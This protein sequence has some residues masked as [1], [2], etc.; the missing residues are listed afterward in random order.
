[1]SSLKSFLFGN[2]TLYY[3]VS[4]IKSGSY[5]WSEVNII[6]SKLSISYWVGYQIVT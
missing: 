1:M 4:L 3:N 2:I 5:G 6:W